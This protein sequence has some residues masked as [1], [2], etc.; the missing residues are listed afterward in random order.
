MDTGSFISK[1]GHGTIAKEEAEGAQAGQVLKIAYRHI[2]F[3]TS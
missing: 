2:N 3:D 1:G